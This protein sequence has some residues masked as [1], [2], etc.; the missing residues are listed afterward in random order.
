MKRTILLAAMFL[1]GCKP[2]ASSQMLTYEQLVNYH[3]TCE[4]AD[5]QLKILRNIQRIKNF[6]PDP[7]M[8]E[9]MDRA[10][11]SRL[12]ATIWWFAY[13]CNKS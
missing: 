6:N 1:M 11:N 13:R 12:K 2:E 3:V 4:K 8:L 10:Y 9:D 7:D 5:E